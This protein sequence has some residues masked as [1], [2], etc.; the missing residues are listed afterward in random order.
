[1]VQLVAVAAAYYY[2]RPGLVS[3]VEDAVVIFVELDY[4]YWHR[5]LVAIGVE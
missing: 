4:R 1:M 5:Q 3:A 2:S